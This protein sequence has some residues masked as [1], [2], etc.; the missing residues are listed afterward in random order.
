MSLPLFVAIQGQLVNLATCSRIY[1]EDSSLC[2]AMPD[3]SIEIEFDSEVEAA[4]AWT[5]LQTLL[6]G[7]NLCVGKL[8]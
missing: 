7:K 2:F 4:H 5:A 8:D 1:V 3:E 6:A